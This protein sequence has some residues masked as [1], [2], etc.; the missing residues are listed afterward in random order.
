[1]M[2]FLHL[3]DKDQKPDTQLEAIKSIELDKKLEESKLSEGSR[4][5]DKKIK[6]KKESIT[7]FQK[8][9]SKIDTKYT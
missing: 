6:T 1:M 4:V 7:K 2:R 8:F 5:Y 9:L 3:P